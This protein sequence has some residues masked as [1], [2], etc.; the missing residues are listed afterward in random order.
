MLEIA[1]KQKKLLETMQYAISRITSTGIQAKTKSSHCSALHC[2]MCCCTVE[3]HHCTWLIF[4][5]CFHFVL[6]TYSKIKQKENNTSINCSHKKK[7]FFLV[8]QLVLRR[9][10]DFIAFFSKVFGFGCFLLIFFVYSS[11]FSPFSSTVN[12]LM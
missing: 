2:S 10:I 11:R 3:L 6:F 9:Q 7:S 5:C 1:R 12:F 8:F 4:S